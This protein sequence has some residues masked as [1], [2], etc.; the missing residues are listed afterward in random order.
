M[1]AKNEKSKRIV[2]RDSRGGII[3]MHDLPDASRRY[4]RARKRT[5]AEAVRAQLLTEQEA[6]SRYNLTAAELGSWMRALDPMTDKFRVKDL[7]KSPLRVPLAEVPVQSNVV[8]VGG[9]GFDRARGTI[10]KDGRAAHLSER[11]TRVMG[12]LVE[13]KGRRV[14]AKDLLLAAGYREE[15]EKP[16]ELLGSVIKEIQKKLVS[17]GAPTIG[18][19]RDGRKT[20]RSLKA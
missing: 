12:V 9:I 7:V 8:H 14:P 19:E 16:S 1:P 10:I 5:I 13:S 18:F 6:M 11:Q 20:F 15:V 4:T 2:A 17:I 3:S